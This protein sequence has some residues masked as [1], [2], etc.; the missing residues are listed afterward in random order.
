MPVLYDNRRATSAPIASSTAW[1]RSSSTAAPPASGHRRRLRHGDDLR[2][3][4]ARRISWRRDLSGDPDFSGGAVPA[5]RQAAARRGPQAADASSAGRPSGRCSRACSWATWTWSR[6]WSGG[7]APSSAAAAG[8]V[9][10]TGGHGRAMMAPRP[11]WS[12]RSIDL[13]LH[14]S[15]DGLGTQPGD[16]SCRLLAARSRLDSYLCRKNDGHL[17]R[18]S[19]RRSS[20]CAGGR[21]R[22][23]RS[24]RLSRDRSIRSSAITGKGSGADRCASSSAKPTSSTRSTNGAAPSASRRRLPGGCEERPFQSPR[25]S[26][27]PSES[28]SRAAHVARGATPVWLRARKRARRRARRRSTHCGPARAGREGRCVARRSIGFARSM[29]S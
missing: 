3:D 24:G 29:P 10:A 4:V 19:A 8:A 2:C 1:R 12:S 14:R 23:S 26:S 21:R 15:P 6:A 27:G 28:D 11:S 18:S 17:I 9:I 16:R 20:R 13:T 22:A 25:K 7:C 5:R